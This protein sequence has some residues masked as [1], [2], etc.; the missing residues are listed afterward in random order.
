MSRDREKAASICRE[1]V[2]FETQGAAERVIRRLRG[3]RAGTPRLHVY[4]CPICSG[5]HTTKG[6]RVHPTPKARVPKFRPLEDDET[7]ALA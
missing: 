7:E 2:R 6:L 1:K 4:R 5:F 3:R